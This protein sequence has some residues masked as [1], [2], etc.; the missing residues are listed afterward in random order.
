M[1]DLGL[2]FIFQN[3][4]ILMMIFWVLSWLGDK[5][6]KTKYY[7]AST[8]TYECGFLSTHLF[9]INFNL[10]FLLI[11]LLLILYD[12]EFFFLI[13]YYFNLIGFSLLSTLIYWIFFI[14]IIISFIIDW[15][16]VLLEWLVN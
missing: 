4:F 2:F 9:N 16:N 13:P 7:V 3:I 14:F 1:F 5:L 12:I 8:E 10:T 6:Y 11:V 15:E